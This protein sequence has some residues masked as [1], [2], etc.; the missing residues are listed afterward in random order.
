MFIKV[1]WKGSN[2]VCI[3]G[4]A[5]RLNIAVVIDHTGVTATL[6]AWGWVSVCCLHM[7]ASVHKQNMASLLILHLL[8]Y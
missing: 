3:F 5:T 8:E 6:V 4:V 7:E 2:E 1:T